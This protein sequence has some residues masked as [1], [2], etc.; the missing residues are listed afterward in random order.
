MV[1]YLYLLFER[2]AFLWV[3]CIRS[4]LKTGHR[5]DW[6]SFWFAKDGDFRGLEIFSEYPVSRWSP[7]S[8]IVLV[9]LTLIEPDEAKSQ[10][11]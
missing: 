10:M 4:I 7:L 1:L 9:F 5:H 6:F 8:G 11:H 3:I 2:A